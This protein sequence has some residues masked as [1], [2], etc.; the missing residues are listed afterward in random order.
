MNCFTSSTP[1]ATI[2]MRDD[3]AALADRAAAGPTVMRTSARQR[4]L[5]LVEQLGPRERAAIDQLVGLARLDRRELDL[6]GDRRVA[7]SRAA[8]GAQLG[9]PR[10]VARRLRR[11][12][13]C[14][15][16]E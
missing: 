13:A 11:Q 12:L 5:E 9:G 16:C 3:D 10:L 4:R 15:C 8:C 1:R 14:R 7:R 2:V 6:P